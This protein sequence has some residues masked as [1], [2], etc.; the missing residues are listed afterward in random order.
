MRDVG[1]GGENDGGDGDDGDGFGAV[2]VPS[3]AGF[4]DSAKVNV[5]Y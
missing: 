3:T 4:C 2:C 5:I 1:C